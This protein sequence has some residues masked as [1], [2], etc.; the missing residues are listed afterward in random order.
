MNDLALSF[1]T[2]DATRTKTFVDKNRWRSIRTSLLMYEAVTPRRSRA[3]D[4]VAKY[5]QEK[6]LSKSSLTGDFES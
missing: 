2:N 5:V 6:Q 3:S 1:W 4:V